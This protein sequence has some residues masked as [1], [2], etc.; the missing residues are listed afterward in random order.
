MRHSRASQQELKAAGDAALE[1]LSGAFPAASHSRSPLKLR[2]LT[3]PIASWLDGA[4]G[5]KY[6]TL[7]LLQ[8]AE[9]RTGASRASHSTSREAEAAK[10]L[11]LASHV[12]IATAQ[13]V[14]N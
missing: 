5:P 8:V 2:P 1:L 4:G 6:P 11:A 9:G 10:Q 14:T 12:S 3:P 7:R 13:C